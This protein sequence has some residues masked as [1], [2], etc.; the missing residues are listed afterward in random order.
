MSAW[1]AQATRSRLLL[2]PSAAAWT[3]DR[4]AQAE[5]FFDP[6]TIARDQ[7]GMLFRLRRALAIAGGGGVPPRPERSAGPHRPLCDAPAPTIAVRASVSLQ[8]RP[9]RVAIIGGIPALYTRTGVGIVVAEG[10][11]VETFEGKDYDRWT[12]LR[13]DLINA[14]AAD[15]RRRQHRDDP[16]RPYRHAHP[17][18]DGDDGGGRPRQLNISAPIADVQI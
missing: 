1:R 7:C 13:A 4:F 2:V 10:K 12:W 6:R 3:A 5:A 16:R 17:V 14:G 18:G 9:K 11:P 8:I 15:F